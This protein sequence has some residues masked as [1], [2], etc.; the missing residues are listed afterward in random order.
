MALL[1]AGRFVSLNKLKREMKKT[2]QIGSP[3]AAACVV[4]TAA[5]G[6]IAGKVTLDGTPPAERPLPLDPTCAKIQPEG[7]KATTH[8]YVVGKDHGLGDVVVYLKDVDAKSTGASAKPLE[9]E[10]KACNYH[11]Y[12]SAVQ[13]GQTIT[14]HNNDPVLHNVHPTPRVPGN[15]EANKAQLPKGAPLDFV[16]TKPEMFLRFKCD[17]HPW[18]FAYVNVFDNPYHAVTDEN[19]NFKITDVPPGKYTL[20][21]EHRKAGTSEKEIEVK[22]DGAKADFT[23]AVK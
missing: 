13:T 12:V 18:M 16:F 17:V 23:L 19:G 3:L 15:P 1:D 14:V 6:D 7:E 5:A 2:L 10:Q 9:I 22:A 4:H 21:V 20:V 11:P 8:F